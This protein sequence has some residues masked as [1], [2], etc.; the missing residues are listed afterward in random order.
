MGKQLVEGGSRGMAY[1]KEVGDGD[2]LAAVP[3]T[4]RGFEGKE[5]DEGGDGCQQPADYQFTTDLL[6]MS[7]HSSVTISSVSDCSTLE[8]S[9]EAA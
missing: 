8:K 5:V 6:K 2:K 3:E 4:D 1:L 9:R 7:S